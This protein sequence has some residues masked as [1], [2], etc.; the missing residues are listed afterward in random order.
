M[1]DNV[2]YQEDL[3]SK[4]I[5]DPKIDNKYRFLNKLIEGVKSSTLVP[6]EYSNVYGGIQNQEESVEVSDNN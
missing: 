6:I 1:L 5:D 4:I 2:G 3:I